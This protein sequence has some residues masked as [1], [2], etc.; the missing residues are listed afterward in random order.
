MQRAGL[1]G[2]ELEAFRRRAANRYSAL[3][4]PPP[5]HF[6]PIVD[7]QTLVIGERTWRVVIDM[8][9]RLSMHRCG[10][11]TAF[12]VAIRTS[13]HLVKPHCSLHGR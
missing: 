10:A 6:V 3:V 7:G 5:E 11:P 13:K 1:T 8:V 9:T 2:I 12:S 4:A